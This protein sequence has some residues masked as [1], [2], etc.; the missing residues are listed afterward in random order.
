M[1]DHGFR[2]KRSAGILAE[3]ANS[4][5][6]AREMRCTSKIFGGGGGGDLF[7]E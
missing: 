4:S 6:L 2:R 1:R 3:N 5:T 7:I